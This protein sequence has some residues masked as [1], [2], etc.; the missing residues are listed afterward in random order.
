M[1][2]THPN[3][4]PVI[5]G[6]AETPVRHNSGLNV[7]ELAAEV[8]AGLLERTGIPTADID[9]LSVSSALVELNPFYAQCVA[10][11][12]GLSTS[13]LHT[14]G[15]GGCSAVAGLARA[16]AAVREGECSVAVVLSADAPSSFAREP[17]R[18]YRHEFEA[19][20]PISSPPT[21]FGLMMSDRAHRFGPCDEALGKIAITQRAHAVLNE[22]ALAK[23][24]KPLT[25]AAYL[26]SRMIAEPLRMLDC[27]MPC[28]GANACIVTTADRARAY[29]LDKL[30]RSRGYAELTNFRPTDQTPD[31]L[32]NGFQAI[33]ARLWQ[34][35][36][37]GP[38]DIGHFQPYDDFTIAVLLQ[39]EAFGFC[40]PGDGARFVA[41]TDLSH[42][43]ALP[44]NT[45][46]GQI[47]CGQPGL[48]GGGIQVTEALRQI[49]GE[50]GARQVRSPGRALVTGIGGI[51]FARNWFSSAA[52]I[53]EAI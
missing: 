14:S 19:P 2:S 15:M 53:L 41:R 6:Y 17:A 10:D 33:S 48:A 11:M 8:F 30:A 29:G 50:G 47:S 9:G 32:A 16:I 37:L 45:G 31:I 3:N 42:S 28:D 40:A 4:E 20:V 1:N 22:N 5:A 12:L 24:R 52:M 51:M 27:V 34:K 18:G 36:G 7:Y 25:M 46:G 38:G 26:D 21:V 49:Y 43:G 39:L 35:S 13:W 23:L 44:L